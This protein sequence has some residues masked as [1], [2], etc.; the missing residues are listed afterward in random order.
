MGIVLNPEFFS[1]GAV[2]NDEVVRVIGAKFCMFDYSGKAAVAAPAI[3][4][5][6]E[7]SNGDK[8]EQYWTVGRAEDWRPSENGKELI[9]ISGKNNIS[10]QSNAGIFLI[11]LINAGFPAARI[12]SDITCIEGLEVHMVQ[13]PAPKRPGLAT[14]KE[15]AT[16]LTVVKILKL[17][18]EAGIVTTNS[19]QASSQGQ[20]TGAQT[21]L[22][23]ALKEETVKIIQ[24][25]LEK[26]ESIAKV[27]LLKTAVT[28]LA[29][30]PK[31]NEIARLIFDDSFLSSGPW[32]YAG[33]V[34]SRK[35]V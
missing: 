5:T 15:N 32:S 8:V 33:G 4:L 13:V 20:N 27:V 7:R 3:D 25:I 2:V 19:P 23:E 1:E 22:D 28:T 12:T 21:G 16:V 11:S 29:G 30:N 6:L 18:W 14:V 35:R 9:P 10:K 26:Q 17:P 34:V 24:S 31:A